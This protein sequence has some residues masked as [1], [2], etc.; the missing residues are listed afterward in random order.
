M[1]YTVGLEEQWKQKSSMTKLQAKFKV[2]AVSCNRSEW[3]VE[4]A[5]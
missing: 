3:K 4:K 2:Y 1:T 5:K